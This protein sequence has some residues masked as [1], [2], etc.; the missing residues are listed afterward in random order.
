M[1]AN[2][3]DL[4][5]YIASDENHRLEVDFKNHVGDNFLTNYNV[6]ILDMAESNIGNL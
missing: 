5:H 4:L 6:T 1:L 2:F 3:K